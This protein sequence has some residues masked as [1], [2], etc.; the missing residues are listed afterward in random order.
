MNWKRVDLLIV[1]VLM[2]GSAVAADK[3]NIVVILVDE[4]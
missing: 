1:F 4:K 3:P 2:C